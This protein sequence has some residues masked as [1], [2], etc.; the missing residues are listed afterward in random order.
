MQCFSGFLFTGVCLRY[1]QRKRLSFHSI[2]MKESLYFVTVSAKHGKYFGSSQENAYVSRTAVPV[3]VLRDGS[4]KSP[5]RALCFR[6]LFNLRIRWLTGLEPAYG[7]TT[8]HCI[9]FLPQP[10]Y[11]RHESNVHQT[12][13]SRP[14]FPLTYGS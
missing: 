12:V 10:Q 1:S 4:T 6:G 8:S 14:V 9:T 3:K 5:E 7:G 11:S 13:R 2:S